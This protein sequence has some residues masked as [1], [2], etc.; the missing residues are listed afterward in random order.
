MFKNL[1][2]KEPTTNKDI[3]PQFT[4]AQNRVERVTTMQQVKDFKARCKDK[5]MVI[6]FWACWY[7]ECED[8]RKQ[9][10]DLTEYLGHIRLAWCDVDTDQEIIDTYEVYKVPYILILHVSY[11]TSFLPFL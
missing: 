6:L 7:P 2:K 11:F 5:M 1:Q 10:E 3:V 8:M 9:F 4:K